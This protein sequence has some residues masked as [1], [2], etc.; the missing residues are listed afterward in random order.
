MATEYLTVFLD[1]DERAWIDEAVRS[2]QIT[3]VNAFIASLIRDYRE[4]VRIENLLEERLAGAEP[5]EP[6]AGFWDRKKEALQKRL[7]R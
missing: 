3:D 1:P 5:F 2:G 6:D 4:K 7:S